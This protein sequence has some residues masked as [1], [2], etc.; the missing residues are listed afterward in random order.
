MDRWKYFGITHRDHVVCN[1]TSSAKLDELVE[2]L[3]LAA[4]SRVLDIACGKAE[5]LLRIVRRHE[6]TGVGVDISPYEFEEAKRRVAAHNLE[7]KV[8]IVKGDGAE[9][10]AGTA[11]FDVAMCIGATWVWDGYL[12]TIE[13]L[14]KIVVPGGLIA[15]GEPYKLKEPDA[16]Y[17]AKDPGF[18]QTLKTHGE[19]VIAAQDAGLTLLYAM[20]SNQ[21][22][23]DRYEGMQTLAAETY[24][25]EQPDDPDL[26]DLL[27]Q[28]RDA[29]TEYFKW[30]RDT[31]S[32][33]IYLFRRDSN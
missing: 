15:I 30:G 17:V 1:P 12:G 29:D 18:M 9:Y 26:P 25:L 19:N 7:D 16:E 11:T 27:K 24:A 5:L 33:A 10:S 6:A 8:E 31:L 13:A 32:W 21:D 22:D 28:R 14:K 3:P 2:L 23:W 4:Q 20:V